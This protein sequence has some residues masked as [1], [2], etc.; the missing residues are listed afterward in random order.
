MNARLFPGIVTI[1]MT[2]FLSVIAMDRD[3][4]AIDLPSVYQAGGQR[5]TLNGSGVRRSAFIKLYKGGLYLPARSSQADEIIRADAPMAIVIDITSGFISSDKLTAALDSGFEK[6]T[7]GQTAHL[8]GQIEEFKQCFG[9]N[10]QIGDRFA[11]VYDPSSGVVVSKNGQQQGTLS[12]LAFKQALFGI[13]LGN[14]PAD[15]GLKSGMLGL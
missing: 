6:S 15:K 11:I 10:I 5:L 2:F 8:A 3:V 4:C 14:Q 7:N 1:A 13:W 12:G 9:D